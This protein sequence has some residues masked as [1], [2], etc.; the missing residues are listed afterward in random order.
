MTG[1]QDVAGRGNGKEFGQPFEQAKEQRFH[2]SLEI[3]KVPRG[4]RDRQSGTRSL[5]IL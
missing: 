3:H 1:E 2:Q 4:R 5:S